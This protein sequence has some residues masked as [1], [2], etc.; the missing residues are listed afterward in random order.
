LT[1]DGFVFAGGGEKI[2]LRTGPGQALLLSQIIDER[3]AAL[4]LC[5]DEHIYG[6][7]E[8]ALEEQ[9]KRG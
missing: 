4:Q 1:T 6:F 5:V 7:I 3:L 9:A 8:A 2:N